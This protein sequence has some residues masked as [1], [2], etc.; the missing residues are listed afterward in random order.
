[1]DEQQKAN[2]ITQMSTHATQL[3]EWTLTNMNKITTLIT[4]VPEDDPTFPNKFQY[5]S[6]KYDPSKTI[7]TIYMRLDHTNKQKYLKLWAQD[8]N[9]TFVFA[10]TC[11][12]YT[13][14]LMFILDD[15]G[16]E[17]FE[18]HTQIYEME[19]STQEVSD[20]KKAKLYDLVQERWNSS[21]DLI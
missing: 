19:L 20:E 2:T 17:I 3:R 7:G 21:Y 6:S 13:V 18:K 1:M 9:I 11:M 8:N 15:I 14:L 10:K 5:I 16:R 12:K 4:Q